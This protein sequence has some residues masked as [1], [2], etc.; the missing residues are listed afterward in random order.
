MSKGINLINIMADAA[1]DALNEKRLLINQ[2][3]LCLLFRI[4]NLASDAGHTPAKNWLWLLMWQPQ[5]LR[6]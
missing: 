3:A 5:Q 1:I 2:E 4:V 6:N